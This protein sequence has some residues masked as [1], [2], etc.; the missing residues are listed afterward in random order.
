MESKRNEKVDIIRGLAILMV[1]LGHTI[2]SKFISDYENN[3]LYKIIFSLQIPLFMIIS[4]YVTI[5]TKPLNTVKSFGLYV[6]KRAVSYLLPWFVWTIILRGVLLDSWTITNIPSKF[7]Y[8]LWHMDTG[9]WFLFSLWTICMIWGISSFIANKFAQKDLPNI[10]I[11]SFI[12]IVLGLGL[13][14]VG[15]TLGL[16][17]LSIK[18]TLY[19]LPFFF[20]GYLFS[21]FY[22]IIEK[23][24]YFILE[25]N[26][27]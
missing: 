1:I 20:I 22:P 13:L 24:K 8:L 16:S 19:Y 27:Y 12:A 6:V 21:K 14:A 9:Y 17:F 7:N 26:R 4:G 15:I 10:I 25:F 18:F 11:T 2:T 23:K 5:F 3:Y